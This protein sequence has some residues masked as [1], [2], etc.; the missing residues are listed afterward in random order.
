MAQIAGVPRLARFC[1]ERKRPSRVEH[2]S[3]AYTRKCKEYCRA[4]FRKL[5]SFAEI[6]AVM[7]DTEAKAKTIRRK[8]GNSPTLLRNKKAS[9]AELRGMTLAFVQ[10]S[11]EHA[12]AGAGGIC[13]PIRE[14]TA[15]SCKACAQHRCKVAKLELRIKELESR[16]VIEMSAQKFVDE[17][18]RN[19]KDVDW[20]SARRK[21]LLLFH[22]DKMNLLC[23]TAG[24][25]FV[26]A[27]STHRR[28]LPC[29]H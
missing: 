21:L 24:T 1:I 20:P 14:P 29:V 11:E 2:Y 15:A 28:W 26:K 8:K 25:A 7:K 9:A 19:V 22:P 4:Q 13:L 27:F 10:A 17:A 3:K 5:R 16:D 12:A 18:R 23:P 6:A